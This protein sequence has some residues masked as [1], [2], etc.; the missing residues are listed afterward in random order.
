MVGDPAAAGAFVVVMV[1]LPRQLRK[2][3]ADAELVR[4]SGDTVIEVMRAV[5]EA[6]PDLRIRLFA[7]SG[8]V[9]PHLALF[10]REE[11]VAR[12]QYDAH[13]VAADDR[14]EI[15][16]GITGGAEDVR[17]R[18]FRQRVSVEEAHSA[19]LAGV[20]RLEAE[21][22]SLEESSGRVLAEAVVSTVAVPAFRRATMDGY[23]VRAADTFGA[24]PYGPI[25]LRLVGEALPGT[26]PAV[27]AGGPAALRIMTGAPVPDGADAVLKAEDA[28]EIAEIVEVHAAVAPSKNVGEIGEDIA[29]GDRVLASGRRLLPQDVGLLSSIGCSP[30]SVVRR[31]RVRVMVSGDELLEPGESPSGSRIVDS[32]SPMLAA[33]IRR[34]G[35]VP[36]VIRTPDDA[37][38]MRAALSAPGADAVVTAGAASVGTEDR[39]PVLVDEL[40]ELIVHGVAM[41]PSSPSGVGRVGATPVLL[42]P[43]NPVSCLVAYDFFAGPVVRR[44]AGLPDEWP[45]RKETMQLGSRL[46]S[47]IGRTD[48]ARVVVEDGLVRSLAISGASVLSSVTRADGFVVIPPGLEGYPAGSDV[49]VYLYGSEI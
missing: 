30:V 5:A 2:Y 33:L 37:S 48:Y 3:A 32:N 18:G 28:T 16:I 23:A 29:I 40:G 21:P 15:I 20:E 47:Q 25:A 36:E 8:L 11:L 26:S 39:V 10:H 45:Y 17:M 22:V 41:R 12:G 14:I 46:V 6:H 38:A 27:L 34:D 43:G 1:R 31:P 42:L 9:H 49:D 7:D 19:A 35:G 4:V 24:S 44:L 13:P